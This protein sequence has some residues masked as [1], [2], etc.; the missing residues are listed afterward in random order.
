MREWRVEDEVAGGVV[1]WGKRSG[2]GEVEG[3]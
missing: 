2:G 1:G 3:E